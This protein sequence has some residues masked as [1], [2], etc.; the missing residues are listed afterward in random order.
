MLSH[1]LVL[2]APRETFEAL[3][4]PRLMNAYI[5]ELYW[6]LYL[7]LKLSLGK[8]SIIAASG[9]PIKRGGGGQPVPLLLFEYSEL[10]LS[11]QQIHFLTQYLPSFPSKSPQLI[12]QSI[13]LIILVSFLDDSH[14]HMPLPSSLCSGEGTNVEHR[15]QRCESQRSFWRKPVDFVSCVTVTVVC[16]FQE[17]PPG[18]GRRPSRLNMTNTMDPNSWEEGEEDMLHSANRCKLIV[19]YKHI[20]YIH[21]LV[22]ISVYSP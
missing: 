17:R 21:H 12:L 5:V 22:V 2:P 14:L 9:G 7:N 18:A 16:F 19:I 3:Q 1:A 8:L 6:L 11:Y 20:K 13:I 10:A 15:V 4:W